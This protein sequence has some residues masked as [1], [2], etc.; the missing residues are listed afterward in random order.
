MEEDFKIKKHI[1]RN[2]DRKHNRKIHL[3]RS[4]FMRAHDIYQFKA[5]ANVKIVRK[6]TSTD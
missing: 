3:A 1:D 4:S 6:L 2:F 5:L